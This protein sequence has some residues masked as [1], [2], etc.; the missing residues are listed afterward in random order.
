MKVGK[1]RMGWY[2]R[3]CCKLE[4]AVVAGSSWMVCLLIQRTRCM[5]SFLMCL[6]SFGSGMV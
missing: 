6:I 4:A 2:H 5:S 1:S 3:C